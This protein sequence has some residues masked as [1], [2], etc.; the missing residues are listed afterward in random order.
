M[1]N[2]LITLYKSVI[3]S[4]KIN[5]EEIDHFLLKPSEFL[6]HSKNFN[7][8]KKLTNVYADVLLS[9][10]KL[11]GI[12]KTLTYIC[13]HNLYLSR[14]Q[15]DC[16]YNGNT[17]EETKEVEL[18]MDKNYSV[19]ISF[20]N[21]IPNL[22]VYMSYDRDLIRSKDIILD[23]YKYTLLGDKTINSTFKVTL[24]YHI[25]FG[26]ITE[27]ISEA[28]YKEFINLVKNN[29]NSSFEKRVDELIKDFKNGK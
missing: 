1:K 27:D 2:K 3:K 20:K 4:D 12:Y 18:P 26:S 6:S 8:K 13:H 14:E 21:C 19:S 28:E 22:I 15:L 10:S 24:K 5:I 17:V 7:S 9:G 16:F 11:N 23:K 29:M 25:N